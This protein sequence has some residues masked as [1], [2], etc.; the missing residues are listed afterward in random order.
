MAKPLDQT[1]L[2]VQLED[3]LRLP[4]NKECVDCGAKAPRWAS[5][6]LGCFMCLR[7]SGIHRAMGVHISK[8]KSVSLDKWNDE[9]VDNMRRVGNLK[10]NQIYEANLPHGFRRV[11]LFHGSNLERFIRDKYE[12]KLYF[13]SN[14]L[15]ISVTRQDQLRH[16]QPSQDRP[17]PTKP[18]KLPLMDKAIVKPLSPTVE[19]PNLV[20]W[21]DP[22]PQPGLDHFGGFVSASVAASSLTKGS[23]DKSS[24]MSLYAQSTLYPTFG[25]PGVS[26]G[27]PV[28]FGQVPNYP[29]FY[30]SPWVPNTTPIFSQGM[31]PPF[32]RPAV[33]H[34]GVMVP[35]MS[36]ASTGVSAS[37]PP[38]NS[39]VCIDN[40][41]ISFSQSMSTSNFK[42]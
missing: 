38:Q 30:S 15:P 22:Q 31:V 14:A 24:I 26:T 21:D 2:I 5:T 1:R 6:N 37:V 42:L 32:V 3:L 18:H 19:V 7:C 36:K 23:T 12:S 41:N 33:V 9:L 17:T 25:T 11:D 13:D 16:V 20:E 35:G 29:Q 8:V 27:H 40:P 28:V 4:T 39:A 10:V 34:Q